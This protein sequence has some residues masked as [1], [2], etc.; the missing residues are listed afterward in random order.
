MFAFAG[1]ADG[2]NK[3]AD[4]FTFNYQ[5]LVVKVVRLMGQVR[6]TLIAYTLTNYTRITHTHTH[7]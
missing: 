7:R 6:Y 2:W 3:S 5:G 4:V 1:L